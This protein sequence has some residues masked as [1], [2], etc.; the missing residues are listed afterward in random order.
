M[1]KIKRYSKNQ[2]FKTY[3]TRSSSHFELKASLGFILQTIS[4]ADVRYI[5]QQPKNGHKNLGKIGIMEIIFTT[6]KCGCVASVHGYMDVSCQGSFEQVKLSSSK[7]TDIWPHISLN[8]SISCS[9][10][11]GCNL[12]EV[13][14]GYLFYL[15]LK[16]DSYGC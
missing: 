13:E 8:E 4:H 12:Y 6:Q 7:S 15:R 5:L 1:T 3:S 2:F 14:F 16:L 11:L 9:T 10:Q